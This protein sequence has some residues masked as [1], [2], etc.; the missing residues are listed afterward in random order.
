LEGPCCR[1]YNVTRVLLFKS[2][3]ELY[4]SYISRH[5]GQQDHLPVRDNN[6]HIMN[7]SRHIAQIVTSHSHNLA[8]LS[9]A[10]YPRTISGSSPAQHKTSGRSFRGKHLPIEPRARGV[11]GVRNGRSPGSQLKD[12]R[13]SSNLLP[14]CR[15]SC[16]TGQCADRTTRET[17]LLT[18]LSVADRLLSG[19]QDLLQVRPG[20]CL[21][22]LSDLLDLAL[23]PWPGLVSRRHKQE[24][25]ERRGHLSAGRER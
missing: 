19:K 10:N 21:L 1:A 17:G 13:R 20:Y 16:K 12:C 23:A 4:R 5:S 14:V 6:V 24:S 3:P 15:E 9:Y 22:G 7:P 11:Y 18:C 25:A 8:A 2:L